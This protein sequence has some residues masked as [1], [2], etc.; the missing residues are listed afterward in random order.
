MIN[1]YKPSEK[2]IEKFTK[3]AGVNLEADFIDLVLSNLPV[4]PMME[5]SEKML[6]SKMIA[7]YLQKN[8]QINYDAKRFYEMLYQNF[9]EQDG[10]WFTSN[11]INSYGDFKKRMKLEGSDDYQ[12]GTMM[13]FVVDEKSALL[14][15]HNFLNE[16][17]DFSDIST[18]FTKL[19][20]IHGDIVPK[21]RTSI[22]KGI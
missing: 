11:Q 10:F 14:W 20:N 19:S 22:T 16:P 3:S 9:V 7:Y 15:L 13:L 2:F 6:Y 5:R 4:Q 12:K 21:E 17:R 1:A 8:Y 18:A